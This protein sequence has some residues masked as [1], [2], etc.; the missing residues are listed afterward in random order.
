M[1]EKLKETEYFDIPEELRNEAD[2]FFNEFD[3]ISD[4]D[5][6]IKFINKWNNDHAVTTQDVQNMLD[7]CS[8]VLNKDG[9]VKSDGLIYMDYL[10]LINNKMEDCKKKVDDVISMNKYEIKNLFIGKTQQEKDLIMFE[11]MMSFHANLCQIRFEHDLKERMEKREND[12]K[13]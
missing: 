9:R 3:K 13:N 1:I 11:C 4:Y 2:K 8:K 6:R 12:K 5:E 7:K 10:G